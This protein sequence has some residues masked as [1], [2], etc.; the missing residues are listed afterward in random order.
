MDVEQNITI[1]ESE[2]TFQVK[3][4]DGSTTEI[5]EVGETFE[6]TISD[7]LG[8][9]IDIKDDGVLLG[10]AKIIDFS[11]KLDVQLSGGEATVTGK[12]GTI[13]KDVPA[14]D[15]I[16]IKNR[17]SLVI[18]GDRKVNGVMKVNGEVKVV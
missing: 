1:E 7:K 6:L 2:D 17:E 12:G 4:V 16:T 10:E 11:D 14:A 15:D 8:S 9:V 18:A 5:K 13:D 3:E